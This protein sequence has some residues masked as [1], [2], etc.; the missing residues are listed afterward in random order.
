MVILKILTMLSA[1][2]DKNG[3]QNCIVL[4]SVLYCIVLCCGE[5]VGILCLDGQTQL[6]LALGAPSNAYTPIM[7]FLVSPASCF[8]CLNLEQDLVMLRSETGVR[9][10]AY[11]RAAEGGQG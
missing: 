7:V 3:R 8:V 9:R 11:G 1:I 6:H 10:G 2:A 4:F 5:V